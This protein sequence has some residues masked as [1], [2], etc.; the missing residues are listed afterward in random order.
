VRAECQIHSST[1]A[2]S[3]T[4]CLVMMTS[5]EFKGETV[6]PSRGGLLQSTL[7]REGLSRV[8]MHMAENKQ[9][10]GRHLQRRV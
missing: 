4:A 7:V 2:G 8:A 6:P 9:I 3:R 5:N 1:N 10:A